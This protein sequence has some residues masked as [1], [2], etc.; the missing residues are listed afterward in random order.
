MTVEEETPV[1]DVNLRN[2]K[3]CEVGFIYNVHVHV[4]NN[5]AYNVIITIIDCLQCLSG[6]TDIIDGVSSAVS[7][8]EQRVTLSIERRLDLVLQQIKE[9]KEKQVG[10]EHELRRLQLPRREVLSLTSSAHTSTAPLP[11]LSAAPEVIKIQPPTAQV[12]PSPLNS[13]W[14]DSSFANEPENP[15][16]DNKENEISKPTG[17][18]IDDA[19]I[20]R[21]SRVRSSR[22]NF[23]ANLNRKLFSEEERVTSNVAGVLGKLKLDVK[24]VAFIRRETYRMYPLQSKENEKKVWSDCTAA[25]DEINR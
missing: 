1:L 16:E 22:Q 13:H 2:G 20:V 17:A 11:G 21:L 18:L 9:V 14:Y 7:L 15:V 25:I 12:E 19:E 3:T 5:V 23:A 6:I 4:H 8:L 10:L 24:K